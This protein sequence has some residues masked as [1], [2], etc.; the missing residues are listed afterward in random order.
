MP[1]CTNLPDIGANTMGAFIALVG[2]LVAVFG[3]RPN[4]P[5]PNGLPPGVDEG[6]HPVRPPVVPHN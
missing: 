4:T 6:P 5:R 2:A 3:H 1:G